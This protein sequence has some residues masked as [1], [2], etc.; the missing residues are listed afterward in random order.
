ME[1]PG[2]G[3]I[4]RSSGFDGPLADATAAVG[5]SAN[6]LRAARERSRAAYQGQQAEWRAVRAELDE[7]ELRVSST[8]A[9][10][11]AAV[12]APAG[13]GGRT[14]EDGGTPS[15]IVTEADLARLRDLRV[16]LELVESDLGRHRAELA[17][18]DLAAESLETTWLFL[19]RSDEAPNLDSPGAT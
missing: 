17:R 3:P 12:T 18:L 10:D 11:R 14:S 9:R 7:L 5:V 16:R 15:E 6:A 1:G 8:G 19:A 13:S 4:P 2:P